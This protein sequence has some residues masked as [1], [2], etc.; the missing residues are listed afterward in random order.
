MKRNLLISLTLIAIMLSACGSFGGDSLDGTS[1][2]LIAIGN[3]S[4]V[5]GST[6]TL[7]FE[8][9]QVSGH[10]GCNSFGGTYKISGDKLQFDQMM[11]TMMACVD[12][13]LMEQESAF[14]KF[15]DDAQSFEIVDG[16][17]HVYRSS[18]D[19]LIFVPVE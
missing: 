16:Q 9:G 1:W 6:L 12:Q 11:S 18:G 13:S 14:M 2:K 4:P 7:A 5:V 15:L 8:N 10:S 17:L 19:A 3:S